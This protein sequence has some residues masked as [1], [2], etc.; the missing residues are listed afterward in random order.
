MIIYNVIYIFIIYLCS[1]PAM[2]RGPVDPQHLGAEAGSGRQND[3][4]LSFFFSNLV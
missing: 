4:E 1:V 2:P 3:G